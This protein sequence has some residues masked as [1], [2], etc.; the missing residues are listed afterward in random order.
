MIGIF[1][2]SGPADQEHIYDFPPNVENDPKV[3]KH[4]PARQGA[5]FEERYQGPEQSEREKRHGCLDANVVPRLPTDHQQQRRQCLNPGSGKA[6]IGD[7]GRLYSSL[8]FVSQ[9]H[10][11]RLPSM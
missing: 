8:Q 1:V 11:S 2:A 4:K 10:C 9:L 6:T 5:G 3:T 7:T